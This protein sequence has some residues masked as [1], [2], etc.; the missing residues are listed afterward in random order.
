MVAI[1]KKI[2]Y[3]ENSFTGTGEFDG[4]DVGVVSGNADGGHSGKDF[5]IAFD[6]TPLASFPH[7]QKIF[8]EVA[9]AVAFSG[10]RGVRDFRSL[11]D[12]LRAGKCRDCF[13][14]DELGVAASM[15]KMEMR[16]DD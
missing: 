1:G 15:I 7:R 4:L 5:S 2:G 14:V 16:V 11:H 8:L 12:I 3:E 13:V 6:G 10:I 9:G